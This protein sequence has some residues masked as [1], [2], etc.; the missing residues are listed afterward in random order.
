MAKYVPMYRRRRS[1]ATD[2]KARK[3]AISSMGVLLAVRVSDRNVSSQFIRPAVEGDEVISSAHSRVLRRLG[4]KGSLKSTPACHLLGLYAGRKAKAKGIEQAYLYNGLSPFIRG[5]RISAFV[6][7]VSDAGVSVPISE[8]ALPEKSRITGE[9][10]AS[11][12]S[13]LLRD[14]REAYEKRFGGMLK[15]GFRP[16]EYVRSYEQTKSA[17]ME[18]KE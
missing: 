1:G 10:I 3:K 12:A 11:Y 6:K 5:S 13:S 14:D 9:T 17:I 15:I 2:Y 16:E 7:G 4:W 8:E 18:A